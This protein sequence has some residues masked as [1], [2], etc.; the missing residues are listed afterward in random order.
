[1]G[2]HFSCDKD[3]SVLP[4]G[5]ETWSER[6]LFV[7]ISQRLQNACEFTIKSAQYKDPGLKAEAMEK[8]RAYK[9]IAE[10]LIDVYERKTGEVHRREHTAKEI[11]DLIGQRKDVIEK[12]L[13]REEPGL[14][15]I[16]LRFYQR[17]GLLMGPPRYQD[18]LAFKKVRRDKKPIFGTNHPGNYTPWGDKLPCMTVIRG[19][20][21]KQGTAL[22]RPGG[23]T[24]T[25]CPPLD[26]MGHSLFGRVIIGE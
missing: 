16:P 4:T 6:V 8:A 19:Y 7:G 3:Y 25:Y 10:E 22:S 21:G 18:H 2:F 11:G 14:I 13:T 20:S 17:Y 1:M 23:V 24:F 15:Y 9:R 5:Y 26:H 12:W